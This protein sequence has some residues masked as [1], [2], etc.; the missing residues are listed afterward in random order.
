MVMTNE[1]RER[2]KNKYFSTTK[3]LV[4]L[5]ALCLGQF[6][7]ICVLFFSKEKPAPVAVNENYQVIEMVPLD[8]E[9]IAIPGL[10]NWSG[11][12]VL[13]SLSLDHDKWRRT[14]ERIQNYFS[15]KGFESIITQMKT[16]EWIKNLKNN[17]ILIQCY[18][19]NPP[20]I[21]K[22]YFI[23][24]KRCWDIQIPFMLSFITPQGESSPREYVCRMTVQRCSPSQN[25]RGFWI[26]M[27]QII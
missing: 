9:N 15:P 10:L 11:N 6:V 7:F 16:K 12:V 20:V 8:Q 1:S 14:L 27:F 26:T 23:D 21:E 24:G 22:Q 5:S 19:T 25:V 3:A 4:M 17:R 2:F 18:V 13:E